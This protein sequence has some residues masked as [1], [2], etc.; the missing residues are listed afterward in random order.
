MDPDTIAAMAA[1]LSAFFSLLA[2]LQTNKTLG[3]MQRGNQGP[4]MAECI[5]EHRAIQDALA[6]GL[7]GKTYFEGGHMRRK[8]WTRISWRSSEDR[9]ASAH[10]RVARH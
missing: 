9:D 10:C 1:A 2:L 5:D 6:G 4:A 3:L 8:R 7:N